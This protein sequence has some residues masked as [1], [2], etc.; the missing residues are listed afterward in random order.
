MKGEF[1]DIL[2]QDKE[3]GPFDALEEIL[4]EDFDHMFDKAVKDI[5]QEKTDFKQEYP[6]S[7][8]IDDGCKKQKVIDPETFEA[9]EV[10][11]RG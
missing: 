8:E 9:I 11:D 2:G 5:E 7:F 4:K 10:P 3:A 6:P 1:D